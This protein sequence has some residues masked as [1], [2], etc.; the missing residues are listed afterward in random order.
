MIYNNGARC[1]YLKNFF[2]IGK[3]AQPGQT[4]DD[5]TKPG[6]SFQLL[7]MPQAWRGVITMQYLA[8][9]PD[10]KLKTRPK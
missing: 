9:Q 8:I 6:P 10:L 1:K 3:G 5:G 7:K 4:L 2:I